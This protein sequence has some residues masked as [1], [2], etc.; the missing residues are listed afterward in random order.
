LIIA[1][2]L[3][4]RGFEIVLGVGH[5]MIHRHSALPPGVQLLKGLNAVQCRRMEELADAGSY[6]VALDEEAFG[7]SD[8][9]YIARD[10]A[11]EIATTAK[12]IFS[13]GAVQENSL[14]NFRQIP[15]EI[16]YRTG[17]P[18]SLLKMSVARPIS[19]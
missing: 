16:I 14:V 6:I 2:E 7:I 1:L 9:E 15:S 19:T 3:L 5:E 12:A 10:V 18:S 11:P 4:R 13:Q 17:N 8:P